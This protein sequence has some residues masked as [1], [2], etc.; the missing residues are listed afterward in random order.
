MKISVSQ[1]VLLDLLKTLILC[2]DNSP[3]A[4]PIASNIKIEAYKDRALL[5]ANSPHSSMI[6]TLSA[7][8]DLP[9]M[10]TFPAQK[11]LELVKNLKK[12]KDIKLTL[13]EDGRLRVSQGRA[14]Y[15]LNSMDP[16]DFPKVPFFKS[17]EY[18]PIAPEAI[19]EAIDTTLYT[20]NKDDI[21]PALQGVFFEPSE[22]EGFFR[23]VTT[24]GLRLSSVKL[25]GVI[26]E[27]FILSLETCKVLMKIL[28]TAEELGIKYDDAFAYFCL[29]DG[30][31]N[32]RVVARDF[33]NYR[34]IFPTA[35]P[36]LAKIPRKD[37]IDICNRAKLFSGQAHKL[38]FHFEKDKLLIKTKDEIAEVC[39][40][41]PLAEG[42]EI[43][44][45]ISLGV[46]ATFILQ[47]FQKLKDD[48]VTL[49]IHGTK[50]PIVISE[51]NVTKVV[52]PIAL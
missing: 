43:L 32:G 27:S 25:P 48:F 1:E 34:K 14:K 9:G 4:K 19:L 8:S 51:K 41:I 17:D 31:F 44:D 22:E 10:C 37:I 13:Q 42:S 15:M 45:H 20:I 16:K 40:E 33:P 46:N 5:Y 39:E 6:K 2:T 36:M 47:A 38:E 50:S 24:D 12:D 23:A 28:P 30:V 11:I 52:M 29:E 21:R 3:T 7:E 18:V 26:K 35:K 49:R